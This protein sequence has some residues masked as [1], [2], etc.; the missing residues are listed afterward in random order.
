MLKINEYFYHLK[1][2]DLF[3]HKNHSHNEIELIQVI[4]GN[5]IVLKNDKTYLLQSHHIYVI[6]ARNAHIVFPEP[7]NCVDYVRNKIVIDA[8]SFMEFFSTI[9][10]DKVVERLFDSSPASTAGNPE[11]DEIYKIVSE[12]C[13][14]KKEE[15][16]AFAHGYIANLVHWIYVNSNTETN[17]APEDTFGKI[18][19][20]INKKDGV[21]SLSEISEILHL[22]KHYLCRLFK[23]KTGI[24]LSDY[25]SDKV[26]GKSRKLLEG[27]SYSVEEIAQKCG[28]SSAAS[29][30]RFFKYKCGI[31]PS[32]FRKNTQHN[33]K[34][35][36]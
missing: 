26:F 27:T 34:L 3:V 24:K 14:S 33:I 9:G 15:N 32:K 28:F 4:N 22:D 13:S 10:L 5:G 12:L 19:M 2:K 31:P 23:E 20:V 18:L 17:N 6:D 16:V 21:T 29:F 11:I 35:Y 36:F 30:S 8:D 25:L 1:G 7:E